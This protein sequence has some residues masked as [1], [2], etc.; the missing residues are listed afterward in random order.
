MSEKLTETTNEAIKRIKPEISELETL[1]AEIAQKNAII[2]LQNNALTLAEALP[3]NPIVEF[4]GSKYKALSPA[5][6]LKGQG[7]IEI[8]EASD[9]Q[10]KQLIETGHLLPIS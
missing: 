8:N 1:K 9:Q 2:E 5:A 7:R 10:I 6:I 4:E 3:S